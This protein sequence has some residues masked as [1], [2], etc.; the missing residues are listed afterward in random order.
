MYNCIRIALGAIMLVCGAH[1]ALAQEPETADQPRDEIDFSAVLDKEDEVLAEEMGEG[2]VGDLKVFSIVTDDDISGLEIDDIYK[3][4]ASFFKIT[5]LRSWDKKGGRFV[6]QRTSGANDPLRVLQRVS[7]LGPLAITARE[8]LIS[9]F[10]SGGTIMYPI[11][12]LLLGVIVIAFNSLW[13][14]RRGR[15]C[16]DQFVQA[17]RTAIQN[18]SVDTVESL[19]VDEKGLLASICR[20]M[21]VDFRISTEEDIRMRCESEARRQVGFL[22]IPLRSLNFIAAVSPLLGLLGT[23]VGMITCFESVAGDAAS[24][25]KSQAMAGGIKVALLT[26]A[27]GLSVAV[28]ALLIFFIFNQR[29]TGIVADCENYTTEFIHKL[30]LIKR[31]TTSDEE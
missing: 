6:M 16:P 7:G 8:T 14:Y 15:Q 5:K 12:L 4:N 18:R 3:S 24:A 26:T 27:F 2:P 20:A 22:R 13:V 28:P 10:M 23:V 21:V 19:A 11:A 30:G 9:R 17:M 31:T 1:F 29:L 25:G